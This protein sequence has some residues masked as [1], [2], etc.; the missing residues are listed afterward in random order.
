MTPSRVAELADIM[1]TT[2]D[3]FDFSRL[4]ENIRAV[5]LG[6]RLVRGQPGEPAPR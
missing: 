1:V 3:P 2:G 5:Y 6:G 4:K